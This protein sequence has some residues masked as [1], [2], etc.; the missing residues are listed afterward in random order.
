[1]SFNPLRLR[2]VNLRIPFELFSRVQREIYRLLREFNLKEDE[3]TSDFLESKWGLVDPYLR[4]ELAVL[5]PRDLSRIMTYHALF[6]A[7]GSYDMISDVP[8]SINHFMRN[9]IV[10]SVY[11]MAILMFDATRAF[12]IL[13]E[14]GISGADNFNVEYGQVALSQRPVSEYSAFH[15]LRGYDNEKVSHEVYIHAIQNVI[16]NRYKKVWL[17]TFDYG[18]GCLLNA[19]LL[20]C[21]KV[22]DNFDQEL[23]N[24][25][26]KD[27]KSLDAFLSQEE[28]KGSLN[29][30]VRVMHQIGSNSYICPLLNIPNLED[31]TSILIIKKQQNGRC[32]YKLNIKEKHDTQRRAKRKASCEGVKEKVRH[33]KHKVFIVLYSDDKSSHYYVI[34]VPWRKKW[35]KKLYETPPPETSNPWYWREYTNDRHFIDLP[36]KTW[37]EWEE[38]QGKQIDQVVR[39]AKQ[40]STLQI[41]DGPGGSGKTNMVKEIKSL[42]S[43]SPYPKIPNTKGANRVMISSHQAIIPKEVYK[44]DGET[45][46]RCFK[47]F[48]RSQAMDEEIEDD[49]ENF[50]NARHKYMRNVKVLIIDEVSMMQSSWLDF[51]DE[52]LQ[53]LH[54]NELLF[55]GVS[56]ILVGDHMQLPP[57]ILS[58]K[59]EDKRDWR[60]FL[61]P[62]VTHAIRQGHLIKTEAPWR[63]KD[64][65]VNEEESF[66]FAQSMHRLRVGQVDDWLRE[67]IAT[68]Y[69][70]E[71]DYEKEKETQFICMYNKWSPDGEDDKDCLSIHNKMAEV[72]GKFFKEIGRPLLDKFVGSK[73]ETKKVVFKIRFRGKEI[74]LKPKD[75]KVLQANTLLYHGCEFLVTSNK[76]HIDKPYPKAPDLLVNGSKIRFLRMEEYVM[77]VE[78]V[79]YNE[80][81]HQ[82]YIF[83]WVVRERKRDENKNMAEYVYAVYPLKP[84]VARTVHAVQGSTFDRVILCLRDRLVT[85][86]GD[87]MMEKHQLYVALSRC[88][89]IE[90]LFIYCNDDIFK[91]I[92]TDKWCRG[93]S[94]NPENTIFPMLDWKEMTMPGFGQSDL[95]YQ[96]QRED[97]AL[98]TIADKRRVRMRN[99]NRCDMLDLIGSENDLYVRHTIQFDI[100]TVDWHDGNKKYVH[101]Q[102]IYY[103]GGIPC[104]PKDHFDTKSRYTYNQERQMIEWTYDPRIA[105]D[106]QKEMS[107][108]LHDILAGA[109]DQIQEENFLDNFPLFITGFNI[110]GFDMYVMMDEFFNWQEWVFGAKSDVV[111]TSGNSM[112][113]IKVSYPHLTSEGPREQLLLCSHDIAQICPG[114][115]ASN[116]E[117]W[118]RPVYEQ[119]EEYAKLGR[120][121]NAKKEK[122][123]AKKIMTFG[124]YKMKYLFHDKDHVSQ[125]IKAEGSKES[126]SLKRFENRKKWLENLYDNRERIHVMKNTWP[127]VAV[128]GE[129]PLKFLNRYNTDELWIDMLN[130]GPINLIQEMTVDGE[131][132][133]NIGFYPGHI[134]KA[135][136][137]HCEDEQ[138]FRNFELISKCKE[139]CAMDVIATDLF[140][141]IFNNELYNFAKEELKQG[142][143]LSALRC[144]TACKLTE[145]LFVLFCPPEYVTKD[146]LNNRYILREPCYDQVMYK[147][148]RRIPGGKTLPRVPS[149]K[150]GQYDIHNPRYIDVSG[151]YGEAMKNN[152]YPYGRFTIWTMEDHPEE[153]KQIQ[154]CL[155]NK[156]KYYFPNENKT[157]CFV[158]T[159]V[160]S[161]HP[162][163]LDPPAGV[164]LPMNYNTQSDVC[165]PK[166]GEMDSLHYYNK[167]YPAVET[168]I[169]LEDICRAGGQVHHIYN[170]CFWEGEDYI[171]KPYMTFLFEGKEKAFDNNEKAKREMYKIF[172]NALFGGLGK[173]NYQK[174]QTITTPDSDAE[175]IH[176]L[177]PQFEAVWELKANGCKVYNITNLEFAISDRPTH[178]FMFVLSYSKRILNRAT[179]IMFGKDRHDPTIARKYCGLYT[180][181]DS[182]LGGEEAIDR[183]LKHDE[184]LENKDRIL[185]Y[186]EIPGKHKKTT[187]RE[188][189]GKFTDELAD[190]CKG[191]HESWPDWKGNFQ[192][193]ILQD[194]CPCPKTYAVQYKLPPREWC[195]GKTTWENCPPYDDP[196]WTTHYKSRMKG[197][198]PGSELYPKGE[199]EKWTEL[200][201]QM[202]GLNVQGN[203]EYTFRNLEEHK[204][205]QCQITTIKHRI[206]RHLDDHVS[207]GLTSE[208]LE[209]TLFQ[210]E[211]NERVYSEKYDFY[212]PK[213]WQDLDEWP[214]EI[215]D[216]AIEKGKILCRYLPI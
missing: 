142:F 14:R 116:C 75:G 76:I 122:E 33:D 199:K 168:N 27:L 192:P 64:A 16:L 124:E 207:Y 39:I 103:Y 164:K 114:S 160:R 121:D 167:P 125:W 129:F 102:A 180:D 211:W 163:E 51:I 32:L 12:R 172:T 212:F 111:R 41:M 18:Y 94:M 29:Q 187:S 150:E 19:V 145:Q 119:I 62:K 98:Y 96:K 127:Q 65:Y 149:W 190:G 10:R 126:C 155:N 131:I 47:A 73:K 77:V 1:M 56:V 154:K 46:F 42:L 74:E 92:V 49:N 82:I 24:K 191:Y 215:I 11:D 148:M 54:H 194:I 50:F 170:V 173:Q 91:A 37:E 143:R 68:R 71:I 69:I 44:G 100:E 97:I 133:W 184:A 147:W 88:K 38:I 151:M 166:F 118:V 153:L 85:K 123:F 66:R 5:I 3:L 21:T 81:R 109:I 26:E 45:L 117:S 70:K 43:E 209:R 141:R 186:S 4:Q 193:Y 15:A 182:W 176:Q 203:N 171:L 197:V 53:W 159:C 57:V 6:Q 179:E 87:S 40:G 185:C 174:S 20:A 156:E 8:E 35:V 188:K 216:E 63:F 130:Q 34:D 161:M 106:P 144:K 178:M 139:Y 105:L 206:A 60:I 158:A 79:D 135:R 104:D 108:L 107:Q 72:S 181:T 58:D 183:L 13:E 48:K 198:Q 210:T 165:P 67:K 59:K 177:G 22:F 120:W 99:Q 204:N 128:K 28:D 138:F 195:G 90:N 115:L 205:T 136:K 52:Y 208:I 140:Y 2:T 83:P 169:T 202:E 134:D 30:L 89:N 112:K 55:G 95:F 132:D 196:S 189:P 152:V 93:F 146:T 7:L 25:Y 113:G 80:K 214:Q 17:E 175:F 31:V 78:H 84:S 110:N 86:Q 200:S 101:G 162:R 201:K 36:R 23:I 137:A 9:R 157:T 213:D 61:H